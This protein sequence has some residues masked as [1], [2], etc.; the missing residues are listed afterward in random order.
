MLSR[1]ARHPYMSLLTWMLVA[2]MTAHLAGVTMRGA[3]FRNY[4]VG[5]PVFVAVLAAIIA[6]TGTPSRISARHLLVI[7]A[8]L[9]LM[10]VMAFVALLIAEGLP[11]PA[12]VLAG[13]L[14]S[15]GA[16]PAG[17][18]VWFPAGAALWFVTSFCLSIAACL[19]GAVAARYLQ[20]HRNPR[21]D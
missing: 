1:V 19:A 20:S 10:V 21:T 12:K 18:D 8:A 4:I 14:T 7:A 13:P 5:N 15:I 6:G 11:G 17:P 16:Y 2:A 9:T 3:E